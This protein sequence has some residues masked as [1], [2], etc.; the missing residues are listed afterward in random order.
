VI[1]SLLIVFSLAAM[2]ATAD[3]LNIGQVLPALSGKTASDKE[4][5]LP[6]AATGSSRVLVFTFSRAASAD[7]RLWTERM[8]KDLG[9]HSPVV[10]YRVIMLESVP[11][12]FRGMALS[13]IR[14]GLPPEFWDK[15]MLLYQDEAL[16]KKRL[17]VI[18]DEH[19]YV[20]LL[21]GEGRVRWVSSGPFTDANY[22]QLKETLSRH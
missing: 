2:A 7:S 12:P 6:A 14:S 9:R 4:L 22:A 11:K 17:S 16:W 19:S 3:Q 1:R 18:T 15:T 13:G 8:A 21:D 5:E 20:V 10:N